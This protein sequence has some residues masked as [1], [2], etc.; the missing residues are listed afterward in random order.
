M[1]FL[2]YLA[3]NLLSLSGDSIGIDFNTASI[4]SLEGKG[5]SWVIS[6]LISPNLII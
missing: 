6:W 4:L 1:S 3:S 2:S 5:K